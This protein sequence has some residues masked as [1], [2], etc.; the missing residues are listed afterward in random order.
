MMPNEVSDANETRTGWQPKLVYDMASICLILGL[1][2]GYLLRGSRSPQPAM[3]PVPGEGQSQS[4]VAM[5]HP[6]PT[7]EQM[8]KMADKQAQPLLAQLK[9]DAKNKDL[10]ARVARVYRSAHQFQEAAQYFSKALA[11]D[12]KNVALRTEMASCLYYN[13]DVDGALGQLQ[14]SLKY[15]PK[16]VNT[17]FNLGMIKW[18]GKNDWAGAIAAWKELLKANPNLDRKPVVEK[19]IAEAQH[20]Q[21]LQ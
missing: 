13:G 9:N 11:V 15:D 2:F 1:L 8:K 6:A 4:P 20:Q 16:D 21:S 19:M 14:Q 7:L 12:P 18:K 5:G 10:L 3:P 17:L